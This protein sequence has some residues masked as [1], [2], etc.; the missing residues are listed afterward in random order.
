MEGTGK[1]DVLD[2]HGYRV[3][4]ALIRVKEFLSQRKK[5]KPS[6]FMSLQTSKQKR[7]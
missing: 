3:K 6:Q 2:L 4:E 7:K 5:G 1:Q